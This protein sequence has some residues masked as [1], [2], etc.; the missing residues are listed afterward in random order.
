[1]GI[2]SQKDRISFFKCTISNANVLIVK[3]KQLILKRADFYVSVEA[4]GLKR[5]LNVILAKRT[6]NKKFLKNYKKR[7]HKQNS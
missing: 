7:S 6:L 5:V 2:Q 1:M 4:I 3:K